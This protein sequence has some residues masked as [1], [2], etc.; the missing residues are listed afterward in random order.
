MNQT[1]DESSSGRVWY[2]GYG[3]NLSLGRFS[4]YLRGGQPVGGA[5]T[6][7]GCRDKADPVAIAPVL[8]PGGIHFAGRSSVW[9]GGM[10]FFDPAADDRTAGRAYLITT[11]QLADV[12][13]QEM[14]REPTGDLDLTDWTGEVDHVTGPGRYETM[15]F[16]GRR[17]GVPMVALGSRDPQGHDLVPP[18]ADYLRTMA[19]GLQEV[20]GWC[21]EEIG[22]YLATRPGA[23]GTW[24]AAE[25]TALVPAG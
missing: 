5:R 12:L 13:A 22:A 11:G 25:V 18:S 6:Y 17:D 20:H 3:S 7:P 4:C 24:T 19:A 10:A 1:V 23:H 21:P 15:I 16:L 8:V 14:R 2:V 9:G